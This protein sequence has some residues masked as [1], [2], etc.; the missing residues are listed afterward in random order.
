MQAQTKQLHVQLGKA[1]E[2]LQQMV[3]SAIP[4]CDIDAELEQYP[5]GMAW[6]ML[7]KLQ[8]NPAISMQSAW[9]EHYPEL[10]KKYRAKLFEPIDQQKNL[11]DAMM[12]VAERPTYHYEAGST[13]DDKRQQLV[14]GE[15]Q[16]KVV[17]IKRLGN[18]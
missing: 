17:R 5:P 13:H 4:V 6:D 15:E 1:E 10:F 3:L 16:D 11:T 9:H 12:K 18:E 7:Q 14:L 8:A 2:T